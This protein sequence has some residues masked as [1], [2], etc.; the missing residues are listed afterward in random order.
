MGTGWLSSRILLM[1]RSRQLLGEEGSVKLS[2]SRSYMISVA[3]L[4]GF[5]NLILITGGKKQ[6]SHLLVTAR[7]EAW[8]VWVRGLGWC[9][10]TIPKPWIRFLRPLTA[11][12]S[13]AASHWVGVGDGCWGAEGLPFFTQSQK[14]RSQP[15]LLCQWATSHKALN[16]CVQGRWERVL[17]WKSDTQMLSGADQ[18][19]HSLG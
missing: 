4:Q 7:R 1:P 9:L 17:A 10:L 19:Q 8:L 2:P 6:A 5:F 12:S 16:C 3:W 11:L 18:S 14:Y 13:A 15:L